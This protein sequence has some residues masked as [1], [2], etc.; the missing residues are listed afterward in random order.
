MD[1]RV[2]TVPHP[3]R[4]RAKPSPLQPSP[5]ATARSATPASG[6]PGREAPASDPGAAEYA[7]WLRLL[8]PA[9]P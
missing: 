7:S 4:M 6:M 1:L 9:T 2:P 3:G 5:A 8:R